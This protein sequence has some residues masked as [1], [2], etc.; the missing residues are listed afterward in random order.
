MTSGFSPSLVRTRPDSSAYWFPFTPK[1][2]VV[3][4]EGG[5]ARPV[6]DLDLA[7]LRLPSDDVRW[8]GVLDGH[9]C[10]SLTAPADF[11]VP[12]GYV[13]RTVRSLFGEWSAGLVLV[14]GAAAQV[15]DFESTHEFCGRCGVH[16]VR[17]PKER[18]R[19]CPSCGLIAYPRVSPAVIVLVR[20][21]REALLARSARFPL[22]FYSTLAGFVE[23]GESL[24]ATVA[25]EIR[26]E[27]GVTVTNLRYF[28]SQ[29]WP[30][31]HSL[32]LAFIA[33]YAG[34]DI[35]VDGEEIVEAR[36]FSPDALPTVPPPLSI[37]RQMIDAWVAETR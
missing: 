4:L 21:G 22:P 13:V 20:R 34:G 30:F 32:M 10:G 8:V 6:S 18:A 33:E 35:K 3:R 37:A 36:W 23:V 11:V 24:E 29:P 27:V 31:P 2:L 15:L 12:E 17:E 28:G 16:T 19:R 26:E 14:A 9:D 25:R 7:E 5:H 1:G